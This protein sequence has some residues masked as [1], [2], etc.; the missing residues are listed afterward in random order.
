[1]NTVLPISN[2]ESIDV[3]GVRKD[4]GLDLVISCAGP[5]DS[6][7]ATLTSLETKICNYLR[8]VREAKD[9]SLLERYGCNPDAKVRIIVSCQFPVHLEALELINNLTEAAH[10]IDVELLLR[11]HVI[12]GTKD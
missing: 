3:V 2:L 12:E 6:S 5:L 11:R 7:G 8:E 9:P 4:G 1:M 10:S